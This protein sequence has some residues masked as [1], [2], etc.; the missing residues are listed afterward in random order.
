PAEGVHEVNVNTPRHVGRIADLSAEEAAR[1]AG[2]WSERLEAIAGDPR[3]LW[4]FLFL[5]QGA[6]AGASLEHTHAQLVGLPFAP[7]HLVARERAFAEAGRCPVCAELAMAG[8]R[9]VAEGE[10]LVAYVPEVPP[11]SGTVRVAPA[12]HAPA[13]GPE[14]DPAAVGRLVRRLLARLGAAFDAPAANLWLYARHP[15]GTDRYHWH[16]D[17]VP[18]L[19]TLAGLELGAGVIAAAHAPEAVAERVRAE[20]DP[21]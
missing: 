9:A 2:A 1:A 14:T 5:N 15:G 13:W 8:E 21:V 16:L 7:P 18:R 11:L 4:P 6:E 10:G 17:A 3:D 20:P 12:R 19:G